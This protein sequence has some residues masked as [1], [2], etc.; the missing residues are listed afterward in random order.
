MRA[1]LAAIRAT[2]MRRRREPVP[3]IA[4]WL[5]RMV[6]G[7]FNYHAVPGNMSRLEGFFSE[8]LIGRGHLH[9]FF[10][11]LFFLANRV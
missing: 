9:K 1:M 3:V 10:Y 8:R 6:R 5:G 2:L 7:Y 11:R 4:R